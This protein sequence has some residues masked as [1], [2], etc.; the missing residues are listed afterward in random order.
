MVK[1]A[2]T[3]KEKLDMCVI[4]CVWLQLP[5]KTMFIEERDNRRIIWEWTPNN[6]EKLLL[7]T[8]KTIE[9]L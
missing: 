9:I 1:I 3:K 5:K 8:F 4:N 7:I 2:T 6:T